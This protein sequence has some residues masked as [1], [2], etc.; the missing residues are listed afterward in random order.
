MSVKLVRSKGKRTAPR[1]GAPSG[2]RL[3]EHEAD[4]GLLIFGSSYEALFT[5]G[6]YGLF[7][8]ISDLRKVRGTKRR[9]FS[10]ADDGDALVLF[11]NELLYLFDVERFMPKR[12]SVERCGTGLE[13][14]AIGERF[15]PARHI[16]RKEVKAVTYHGYSIT[17]SGGIFEA[18]VIL[19]I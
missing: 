17:E 6:A 15:D 14:T 12:V 13:A 18:Q 3:V 2:Y 7:S 10:V 4:A 19:D 1:A 11:L 5:S 9:V 8:I 16:I